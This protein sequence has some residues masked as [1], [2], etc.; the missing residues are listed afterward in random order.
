MLYQQRKWHQPFGWVLG[1]SAILL[2]SGGCAL[3]D[4]VVDGLRSGVGDTIATIVSDTLLGF[5]ER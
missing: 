4:S 2:S 1:M 3:G 5:L